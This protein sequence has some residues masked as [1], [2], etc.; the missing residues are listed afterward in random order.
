LRISAFVAALVMV[1][2]VF[3]S[4]L[5]AASTPVLSGNNAA[6]ARMGGA[7]VATSS[8]AGYEPAKAIDASMATSWASSAGTATLTVTFTALYSIGEAHVHMVGIAQPDIDLRVDPDG[9]G[10]SWVLVKSVRANAALD[11]ILTFSNVAA[12]QIRIDFLT[13]V[14]H[15]HTGTTEVWVC[16]L[17][18]FDPYSGRRICIDGHFETRTTTYMENHPPQVAEFEAW[19]NPNK[20]TDGDG[21]ADSFEESTLYRQDASADGLPKAIPNNGTDVMV[22]SLDRPL[23]AGIATRAFLDLEIDHASPGDLAVAVG[24]WNGTAWTDKLAWAPGGFTNPSIWDTVVI[25]HTHTTTTQVWVC[26]LWDFD[27]FTWRRYCAAG[28][29]ETRTTTYTEDHV[30]PSVSVSADNG[31]KTTLAALVPPTVSAST[32]SGTVWHVTIDLTKMALEAWETSAGFR[33]PAIPAAE[34]HGRPYWRILVRDWNPFAGAGSLRAAMLRTEER[35]DPMNADTDAD[36]L[37]DGVEVGTHGTF[38]IAMDTDRDGVRDDF[39]AVAHTITYT[40]DGVTI[41][42][43][44]KTDPTVWDT[45]GDGLSDG[46][47]YTL[48]VDRVVTNPVLADT[49]GDTL[50][51]GAELLTYHSDA[52]LTDT[53]KDTI[54]DNV[55]VTPRWLALTVNGVSQSRLITTLP[56]A[57]DSDGDGLR[58][59][60]EFAG[61]TVYGVKTDPSARDTDGDGLADGSEK[62]VKELSIPTRKTMG[63]SIT[64]SL[65]ATLSGAPERVDVRYGLS[66]IAVSNFFVQL[67]RGTTSV[68]L[69]SYQG[70]GLYNYSSKDITSSFPSHGGTYSLYVYSPLSGGVLEEFALSFLFRTSPIS[71]DSDGDGLSDSEEVTYGA[72]GW[73]TD[74]NRADTDG[75]SWS[76]GYEIK[77]AGTNPLSVDTDGDGARDNVD[78]DPLRNLLVGVTVKQ[79]HHGAGPWC[80]PELVGLIRINNDYTWVSKHEIA[81]QEPFTSWSCPLFIPTTQYSTASF[82]YTYYA[83]VPDDASSVAVRATAWAINPGRGDD[84][85]VDQAVTYALN[86]GTWSCNLLNGNSWY[87]FDIWTYGLPKAKALLITDGNA[88]VGASN[89]QNRITGQDRYIVLALDVTSSYGPLVYGVNSIVV[90]RA[91]FLESKLKKDFDAASYWPLADATLYGEDLGKADVSEGVAG[92][93]AKSLSG[94]DAYNVLDRLLRNRTNANV[95]GYVDISSYAIVS[96]LPADVVRVLPWAAVWNGPTGTMPADF[97]QKIGAIPSTVVNSIVYVGQ[98]I[99]KGLVA[100]GTFLVNLAQAIGDWGL[101]MLGAVSQA[102]TG[103]VNAVAQAL[104]KLLEAIINAVV[105]GVRALLDTLIKPIV[106]MITEFKQSIFGAIRSLNTGPSADAFATAMGAALFSSQLFFVIMLLSVGISVAEKITMVGSGGFGAILMNTLVPLVRDMLIVAIVSLAVVKILNSALPAPDQIASKVPAQF[107]IVGKL[108]FGAAKFLEKFGLYY[109][110]ETRGFKS[111][112]AVEKTFAYAILSLV[113]LFAGMALSEVFSPI[114]ATVG[115]VILDLVTVWFALNI[116]M[117]TLGKAKGPLSRFYPL[118]FPVGEA[119]A[120]VSA[121]S[122]TATLISDV[123]VLGDLTGKW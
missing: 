79:I 3:H 118:M 2:L 43:T 59:D 45:D 46:E 117:P 112:P 1:A 107:E 109:A 81:S 20:D 86:S 97:W 24:S 72:D 11:V 37:R 22:L 96:N 32:A 66:T 50:T 27:E 68:V 108:S 54:P 56:Y 17:W 84:I 28:H 40:V 33:A 80:S 92:I 7:A 31:R 42:K 29:Y 5:A 65:D 122:A 74:P 8:V 75:D 26:D 61:T 123:F 73:I 63:T 103:A 88:T 39:E 10:T 30:Y 47:E 16:D 69:R 71:Q 116:T 70:S 77:T 85:L 90:P 12:K 13:T 41:T 14:T 111:L 15:T 91:I 100:L 21:L 62:Y 82:Y 110:A 19:G 120:L 52:T 35:S 102:V 64:V 60:Q 94:S 78:R 67:T 23:W 53:D 48:G 25:H 89:G 104:N 44:V 51:D 4:P 105:N 55:E 49:D 98:L 99:H 113:I 106:D 18:D 6:L 38:P 121:F 58:D 93:I 119:L 34:L 115:K 36:T 114:P 87:S 95:Y 83:D 57:Q 101:R 76:D 9:T